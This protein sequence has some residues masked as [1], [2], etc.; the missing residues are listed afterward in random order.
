MF[1]LALAAGLSL[2]LLAALAVSG[3]LRFVAEDIHG[4][5]RRGVALT[6]LWVVL[7]LCVFYPTVSPGAAAEVDPRTIAFS[8]IFTGQLILAGF[9]LVWWLLAQPLPLARFLRLEH[10]SVDDVRFG[11]GVGAAAWIL[12]IS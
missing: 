8:T 4:P 2:A 11:L 12:A 5:A 10:G 3:R 9:L 6:V 7:V 1:D